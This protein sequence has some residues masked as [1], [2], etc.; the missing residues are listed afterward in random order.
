MFEVIAN[1]RTALSTRKGRRISAAILAVAVIV[2][3]TAIWFSGSKAAST[4]AFADYQKL[5]QRY[6]AATADETD[7]SGSR[8]QLASIQT[9]LNKL[10]GKTGT[11]NNELK[12]N[13]LLENEPTSVS[14]FKA[15]LAD[16]IDQLDGLVKVSPLTL[17]DIS[18]KNAKPAH[19]ESDGTNAYVFDAGNHNSISIVNLSTGVQKASTADASSLGDV[20]ATTL[21]SAGDGIY[22]LTAKPAVWF[23]RFGSD[24]LTLQSIAYSD[25]PKATAIASYGP[26]LYLLGTDTVYKVVRN[27][28]GYSPKADYLS[29]TATPGASTALAVDGWIYVATGTNLNRFLAGSLN[30]SYVLPSSVGKLTNLRS[31]AGGSVLIAVSQ[32]TGRINVW[33]VQSDQVTFDKQIVIK[34]GGTIYDATY[35]AH[36]GKVFATVGGR[37]VSFSLKP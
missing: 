2:I 28:T 21:S 36:L 34:D 14:D 10:N 4:Q 26:N 25:W 35:D 32:S 7:K 27:A 24:T 22:V 23:Y 37:V 13:P 3:A 12:N 1:L 31:T 18:G 16:Q 29:T 30:H 8:A 11:I 15:L 17:A 33:T 6:Q 20:V 9:D 5:F 19:F